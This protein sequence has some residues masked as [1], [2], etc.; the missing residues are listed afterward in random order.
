MLKE[1][2]DSLGKNKTWILVDR[3]ESHKIV[4]CKWIYKRKEGIPGV[5]MHR[6]KSR[7]VS[8]GYT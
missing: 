2:L 8:N 4:G 3:P 6:F 1:E 7:L 5:K